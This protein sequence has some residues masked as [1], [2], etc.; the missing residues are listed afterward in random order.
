METIFVVILKCLTS[1]SQHLTC[2]KSSGMEFNKWLCRRRKGVREECWQDQDGPER[3]D[4][5]Q[6][7]EE[8]EYVEDWEDGE[9]DHGGET[10]PGPASED[11]SQEPAGERGPSVSLSHVVISALQLQCEVGGQYSSW[12]PIS[13]HLRPGDI[14]L[15]SAPRHWHQTHPGYSINLS[16]SWAMCAGQ[17]GDAEIIKTSWL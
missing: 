10:T 14:L 1:Q 5:D 13:A 15:L 6:G 7:D 11:I 16:L 12:E 17:T 9:D 8:W 4:P 3:G 2:N